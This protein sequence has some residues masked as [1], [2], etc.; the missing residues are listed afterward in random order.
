MKNISVITVKHTLA[1]GTEIEDLNKITIP[2]N[3]PIYDL[4]AEVVKRT[5]HTQKIEKGA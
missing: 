1:D 4:L 5:L 2:V 3:N